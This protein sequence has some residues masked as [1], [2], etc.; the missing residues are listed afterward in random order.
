VGSVKVGVDWER[1]YVNHVGIFSSRYMSALFPIFFIAFVRFL[2]A[3]ASARRLRAGLGIVV[4]LACV[5]LMGTRSIVDNWNQMREVFWPRALDA[6]AFKVVCAVLVAG[7]AYY[8]FARQPRARVYAG[9]MAAWAIVSASVLL[10]HEFLASRDGEPHRDADIARTVTGLVRADSRDLGHV[11]SGQVLVGTRFMSR[12]PGIV[13]FD[14]VAA[15]SGPV[16]RERMP[17]AARWVVFLAGARPGFDAHCI[18][19]DGASV[20]ALADGVLYGS[21]Q[22]RSLASAASPR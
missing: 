6:N 17:E 18:A 20:C 12:F 11:V 2:P 5:A 16:A 9:V 22:P 3:A 8:A 15:A 21:D 1:V 4:L 19:L 7:M 13:S 10:R 14:V